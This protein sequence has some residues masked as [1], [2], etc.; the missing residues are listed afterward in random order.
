MK[1]VTRRQVLGPLG[2]VA[3]SCVLSS[4]LS[5]NLASVPDKENKP[6]FPW[7]Y[8]ELDPDITAEKTYY[9]CEKGHCM[10]GVFAPV[11]SQL[12]EK[13]GEPYKSF[14]VDMMRYGV[15]GTAGSG[16]L[17]GSLNGAAALIGLF[18]ETEEQMKQIVGEL[19]L[20]YEQTKSLSE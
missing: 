18:T 13:H 3:G 17:C 6:D 12:A 11:I 20:W 9:D 19:F 10:Y 8:T 14:P 15:G 2:I 4:C 16:S 7:A 5:K 1:N